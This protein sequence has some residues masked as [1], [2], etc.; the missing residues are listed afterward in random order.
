M[1]SRKADGF[2]R[3]PSPVVTLLAVANGLVF[4]LCAHGR[5]AAPVEDLVADGALTS[6][7]LQSGQY[8][9]L[10]AC[11]FLHANVIHLASNLI[12]LFVCGPLLERRLGPTAFAIVYVAALVGGSLASLFVHGGA[13]VG[14]GAS[15]A[16]FGVLGALFALWILGKSQMQATFFFVNFGLQGMLGAQSSHI[17]WA[18]HLGGFCFGMA[19]IAILDLVARGS[20]AVLRC[21]FPEF[22]KANIAVLV[23]AAGTL[24]WLSSTRFP[25]GG[26]GLVDVAAWAVA[27]GALVMLLD[28]TLSRRRGLA[29]AVVVL[30]ACN[31]FLAYGAASL[32]LGD[33]LLHPMVD[34]APEIAFL[35]AVTLSGLLY[36]GAFKRGLRDVG[37]LSA[38]LI[39]NRRRE[40]GL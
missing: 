14:V 21:K 9:R 7:T 5:A 33:A 10:I 16:I 31:G 8:W 12:S 36:A 32:M 30:T 26:P 3:V 6:W 29:G 39:G 38:M 27:T 35:V 4:A 15:G 17:D 37:F 20:G 28:T 13:F 19:S 1:T 22:V 11:G 18:A 23:A 34:H 25:R 2:S 24:I 40:R